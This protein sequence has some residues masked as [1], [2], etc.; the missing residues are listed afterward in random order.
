MTKVREGTVKL[1]ELELS[2]D[3]TQITT[4]IRT[5]QTIGGQAIFEIGRRLKKVKEENL[6]HG[7]FD[8][9][10]KTVN[11]QPRMAQRFMKVASSPE[12][13]TTS[14][15]HLGVA[16]LY[17]I[18]TMP[19]EER[20]K[21]QQLDSGETKTPDEMT[22][23]ELRELKQQLKHKDEQIDRQARMIDDL[24]EQEPQIVEKEVAVEKTP[25]DYKKAKEKATNLEHEVQQLRKR[26]EFIEKQYQETLDQM[27]NTN[28]TAEEYEQLKENISA[29]QGKMTEQ[30]EELS[31]MRKITKLVKESNELLDKIAP[32][33]YWQDFENLKGNPAVNEQVKELVKRVAQWCED[34]EKEIGTEILEGEIINE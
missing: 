32:I 12:L 10:L 5:Y 30:Q 22:V 27:E 4:E 16:A 33:N 13:N 7:E 21:P 18:A 34:M 15:S 2:N 20:E 17:E 3:L 25:Y 8:E 11:M 29:M 9:W 24:N 23:R 14:M 31:S 1:N 6:A 19:E 26:N 28:K